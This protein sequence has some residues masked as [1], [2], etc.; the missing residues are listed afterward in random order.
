MSDT[1]YSHLNPESKDSIAYFKKFAGLG[2]ITDD[3]QPG[4]RIS[5]KKVPTNARLYHAFMFHSKDMTEARVKYEEY[6]EAMGQNPYKHGVATLERAYV[7]GTM[8]IKLAYAFMHFLNQTDMIAFSPLSDKS[9]AKSFTMLNRIPITYQ[10]SNHYH[11][12]PEELNDE[13]I[14]ATTTLPLQLIHDDKNTVYM[15]CFDAH[16]GRIATSKNGLLPKV[17]KALKDANKMIQEMKASKQIKSKNKKA[18]KKSN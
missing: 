14:A 9:A 15:E 7:S 5:S 16:P 17:L 8:D 11:P 18:A 1:K 3:S 6:Q 10:L 4:R 13:E 2:F 12:D